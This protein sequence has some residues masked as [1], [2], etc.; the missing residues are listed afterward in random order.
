MLQTSLNLHL[1]TT[2][3]YFRTSDP[4]NVA[5]KI[6]FTMNPKQLVS[7]SPGLD[8]IYRNY[9]RK[10]T[11]RGNQLILIV[12]LESCGNFYLIKMLKMECSM[13]LD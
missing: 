13:T 11:L 5:E 4:E 1:P 12:C 10:F 2:T 7:S 8:P 9:E 3:I 6:I